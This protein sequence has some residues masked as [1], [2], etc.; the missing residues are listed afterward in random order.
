LRGQVT[1]VLLGLRGLDLKFFS[2][3]ALVFLNRFPDA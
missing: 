1:T 3:T 2:G